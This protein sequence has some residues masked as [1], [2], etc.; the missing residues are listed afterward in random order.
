MQ[1]QC[2]MLEQ[3]KS[4]A[5]RDI[6]EHIARLLISVEKQR[7]RLIHQ[8]Y[9]ACD[10]Q[11]RVIHD[12]IS[13]LRGYFKFNN[14]ARDKLVK[15]LECEQLARPAMMDTYEMI[16]RH[17]P[18]ILQVKNAAL[19]CKFNHESMEAQLRG[20]GT[21]YTTTLPVC[22]EQ[23]IVPEVETPEWLDAMDFVTLNRTIETSQVRRCLKDGN[24][25][26]QREMQQLRSQLLLIQIGASE[27]SLEQ[28]E[29]LHVD[30]Y[31]EK[32]INE[33]EKCEI[34]TQSETQ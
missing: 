3:N 8:V 16:A 20:F 14:L 26:N 1:A 4:A 31:Y 2:E 30:I 10:E 11:E 17:S 27:G 5:L 29:A 18:R 23:P 15:L 21:L 19:H 13:I 6:E 7:C 24:Q 25:L 9:D 22:T 34:T 32:F 12:N 33:N 28:W